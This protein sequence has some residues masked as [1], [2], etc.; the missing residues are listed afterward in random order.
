MAKNENIRIKFLGMEFESTN[1]RNRTV[2]ILAMV[3][4]FFLVVVTLLCVFNI[5]PVDVLKSGKFYPLELIERGTLRN[6]TAEYH[7]VFSASQ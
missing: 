4:V 3:L 6:L 7:P 2:L 5:H 1:I